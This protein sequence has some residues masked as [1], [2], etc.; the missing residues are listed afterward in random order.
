[1]PA[2]GK[3]SGVCYRK[4]VE[5]RLAL[6]PLALLAVALHAVACG[7]S[8]DQRETTAPGLAL[9]GVLPPGDDRTEG[10]APALVFLSRDDEAVVRGVLTEASP[11]GFRLDVDGPPPESTA[12]AL[13][14]DVRAAL[15]LEGTVAEAVLA[16][17]PADPP[18]TLPNE[19][20]TSED[21]DAERTHC[22]KRTSACREGACR[23]RTYE[24]VRNPCEAIGTS[25]VAAPDQSYFTHGITC[26]G[27]ACYQSLTAC[28]ASGD[29]RGEYSRCGF[30]RVTVVVEYGSVQT[31]ELLEQTGDDT[32]LTLSDV[33]VFAT[34]HYVTYLT[35][36][37]PG[38]NGLEL[39]R[40]YNV[41]E[42]TLRSPDEYI[43]AV[44]CAT[45][46]E[47]EVLA[48]YNAERGT[49]YS[50]VTAPAEVAVAVRERTKSVC[51]RPTAARVVTDAV[52][53]P[54]TLQLGPYPGL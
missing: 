25:G 6:R 23:E 7:S 35:E 33:A 28:T 51:E 37:N 16:F 8:N 18:R 54:L 2:A 34:T 17:L 19:V 40:G 41:V 20:T 4:G 27:G 42:S 31:C 30:D 48:E 43:E 5:Q 52:N 38:F 50:L 47:F 9:R 44:L 21:C 15:G 36:D 32:I 12:L 13:T 46:T 45:G 3:P 26:A 1:M 39:V 24:C 29:C 49:S 11:S 10:L 22:T 53:E 14:A